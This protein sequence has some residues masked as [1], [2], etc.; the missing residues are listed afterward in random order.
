VIRL[1]AL[2]VL[3]NLA[4]PAAAA[5]AR[6][7]SPAVVR[8]QMQDD[9]PD[10]FLPVPPG[11]QDDRDIRFVVDATKAP[12]KARI[13][14]QG[15]L[16]AGQHRLRLQVTG[17]SAEQTIVVALPVRRGRSTFEVS[18]EGQGRYDFGFW[19]EPVAEKQVEEYRFTLIAPV[20]SR[21]LVVDLGR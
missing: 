6:T 5:P 13:L 11:R 3:A 7:Q 10:Y 15:A 14:L 1:A 17:A 16:P 21:Q 4:T 12:P 2:A 8:V 18:I 19:A 9:R 20:K